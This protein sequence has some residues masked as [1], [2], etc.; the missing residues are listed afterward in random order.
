MFYYKLLIGF[1]NPITNIFLNQPKRCCLPKQ[2]SSKINQYNRHH[3][4]EPFI[5]QM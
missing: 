5:H 4:M 3:Q 1:T 2:F